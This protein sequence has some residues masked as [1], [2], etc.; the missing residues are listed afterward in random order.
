M[1]VRD[2]FL[3]APVLVVLNSHF[4]VIFA[5]EVLLGTSD[6]L[7]Q[8]QCPGLDYMFIKITLTAQSCKDDQWLAEKNPQLTADKKEKRINFFA[9]PKTNPII[10]R[11]QE[12]VHF[13]LLAIRAS[14][15]I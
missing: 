5:K 2:T 9:C 15:W 11:F 14:G 1:C 7:Y 13:V 6:L 10:L 3:K 4:K 8:G 12:W